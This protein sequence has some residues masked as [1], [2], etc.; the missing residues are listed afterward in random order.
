[1]SYNTKYQSFFTSNL[2]EDYEILLDY[3]DYVGGVTNLTV[4]DVK[5]S[6]T[7][8]DEDRLFPICGK[9]LKISF[10]IE[11][12]QTVGI[13][14][15]ISTHDNDI[16]ATLNLIKATG[17]K[18][19]V[20]QGFVVVEDNNQPFQDRP[21]D[22]N[23]RALDGLGLLKGVDLVDTNG[24]KFVGSLTV[25]E[26]IAQLLYKTQQ[27]LPIRVYFNFFPLNFEETSA[28]DEIALNSVTFSQGDAFNINNSDPTIDLNST[29]ADDVFTALEKII[30]CFR[31]R[32]FM[33][34]GAWRIV[35]LWDHMNPE[36]FSYVEFTMLDPVDGIVPVGITN[37]VLNE[38]YDINIGKYQV[39][40]PAA[41]NQDLYLKLATKYVKLN[42][43]Y[44]QSLNK[45]C[46]QELKEGDR[47]A[48][49]DTTVPNTYSTPPPTDLT[50]NGFDAYCW[51]HQQ[52]PFGSPVAPTAQAYIG[53]VIDPLDYPVDRYLVV[54]ETG[55]ITYFRSSEVLVDAGDKLELSFS[56]R[57]LSNRGPQAL[58]AVGYVLFYGDDGSHYTLYTN[59]NDPIG[60]PTHW[61]LSNAGF[62]LNVRFIGHQFV[63]Q[64][65]QFENISIPTPLPAVPG[66]GHIVLILPNTLTGAVETWF[67]DITLTI[68]PYLNNSYVELEGDYN[69]SSIADNIKQSLTE[70]VEI[71]DSPKR[72]FKG[73]LLQ[74]DG[75]TLL[76]PSFH[77][78]GET[79][80]ESFRFTQGMERIMWNLLNRMVYKIEG[81]FKGNL[82]QTEDL[83][84]HPAGFQNNYF[85]LD[86][87][88]PTKKFI[89]TSFDRSIFTGQGRHVFVEIV[90]DENTDPFIEPVTPN[91]YKF[92]YIFK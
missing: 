55:A 10:R 73:A 33:E 79:L 34:D 52:G 85:F 11:V 56:V 31:C 76:Q 69:L 12:D 66:Q 65:D 62:T 46:N 5:N 80:N 19:M 13:A 22:L 20:F 30:R 60:N 58:A 28:F 53:E 57:T 75:L 72:Y 78:R 27:T 18:S 26:W 51:T 6:S 83:D 59:D 1:M 71:S 81:D 54:E 50:R 74:N 61:E 68:H 25:I 38:N 37:T 7:G 47:N 2:S 42:Y 39:I 14:D 21:F 24:L 67:K 70:T 41:A 84:L 17:E 88:F 63:T 48:T 77:R 23:I 89:L 9:E 40:Y 92:D 32:I 44:D 3:L 36:G 90:K 64:T 91:I 4:S 82:W 8:G 45:I 35:N 49:Y 15:L 29:T 86:G 43:P 87:D 16:R